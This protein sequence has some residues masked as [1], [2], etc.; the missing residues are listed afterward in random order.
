MCQNKPEPKPEPEPESKHEKKSKKSSSSDST[1]PNP[2]A[3][4]VVYYV[5]GIQ[6]PSARAGKQV[7]GPAAQILFK[8]ARAGCPEAF[9][10]NLAIEGKVD[11]SLKNGT[12]SLYIPSEYQKAGRIFAL[13]ALDKTGRVL[14]YPDRDTSLNTITVN[15]NVEGYAFDLIYADKASW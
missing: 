1:P 4:I 5:N 14:F 8:Q 3:L 12:M 15:L 13:T 6:V 9:S 2:D 11:Q 7:Q 10:F